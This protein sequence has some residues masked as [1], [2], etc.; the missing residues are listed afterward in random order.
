MTEYL[1]GNI[2]T[3]ENLN[4]FLLIIMDTTEHSMILIFISIEYC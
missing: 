4:N 1:R 2:A 3:E